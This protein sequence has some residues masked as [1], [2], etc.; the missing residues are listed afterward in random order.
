MA[1]GRAAVRVSARPPPRF[2]EDGDFVLWVQRFELYL[3]ETEVPPTKSAGTSVL[4]G[5]PTI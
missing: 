2:S 3:E 4:T 1:E 5:R